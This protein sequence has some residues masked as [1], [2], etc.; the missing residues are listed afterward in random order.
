MIELHMYIDVHNLHYWLLY[1]QTTIIASIT[2]TYNYC[3][4]TTF[5]WNSTH[6]RRYMAVTD[7]LLL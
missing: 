4:Y 6:T 7:L 3:I 2:Y 1:I 5:E